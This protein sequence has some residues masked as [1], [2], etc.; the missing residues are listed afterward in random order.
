MGEEVPEALQAVTLKAMSTDRS[1]R[2]VSVES[3]AADI[4]AYQNGFATS[5][6]EA[7]TWKRLRLWVGR[8]KVLAGAAAAMLVVVSGFTARVIQKGREASEALQSLRETAPTFAVRAQD[9]LRDGN[10]EDALKAATF[11]VKLEGNNGEYHAMRGNALQV[12]M[13]WPEAM[14]EYQL[15]LR[16][17]ANE[18]AQEN[19]ILTEDLISRF[20][21]EGEAKAKGVLFA[22]LNQQGRNY[23]AMTLVKDMKEFWREQKKDPGLMVSLIKRLEEKLLPIPGTSVLMCKTKIT[24]REWNMYL[25]SEGLPKRAIPEGLT[26][27]HPVNR[28]QREEAIKLCSLLSS[29]SGK[30]WRLPTDVEWATA[31][32]GGIYPWGD[33]WP[34]KDE[35]GVYSVNKKRETSEP[36]GTCKPNKIGMLD[37]GGNAW[38]WISEYKKS[39]ALKEF[40]V[41]GAYFNSEKN[42]LLTLGPNTAGTHAKL[43]GGIGISV[44][45]VVEK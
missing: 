13:R 5:A 38:E 24:F 30:K 9:A 8:N 10:F 34:P 40:L 2:Y 33:Y 3:F 11:A 45:V 14:Q 23:E 16:A 29:V 28:I 19:L 7:G 35:D 21:T 12:L 43:S 26:E 42:E 1:K 37:L 17:G 31:A 25:S 27:E 41:G 18:R 36:V 32:G 39:P 22:A 6:E 15:A 20:K 4:E 44:R